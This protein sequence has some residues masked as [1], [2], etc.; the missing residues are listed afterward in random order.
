MANTEL[1][2]VANEIAADESEGRRSFM[3][4]IVAGSVAAGTLASTVVN[5]APKQFAAA[6]SA[7]QFVAKARPETAKIKV[8][9]DQIRQPK[10]YDLQKSLE[11]ILRRTGCPNCGLGGIDILLRL[12]ELINPA[13]R[14]MAIA[15]GEVLQR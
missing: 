9:F 7:I 2:T 13:E 14:F 5:A 12:D 10:L 4:G 1:K 3:K 15:E 6:P 11:D 8:S